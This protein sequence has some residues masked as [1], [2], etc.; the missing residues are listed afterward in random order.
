MSQY[1]DTP[2]QR[3]IEAFDGPRA[4][5][6]RIGLDHSWIVRWRKEPPEGT[7]GLIPSKHHRKILTAARED[8][9]DL[10]A[11]DLIGD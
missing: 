11:D 10:T 4:L 2:A 7:G 1:P 8:G 3:V 6:R 5:A 9:I